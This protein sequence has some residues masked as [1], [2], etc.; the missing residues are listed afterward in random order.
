MKKYGVVIL[1]AGDATRLQLDI[2]KGLVKIHGAS[3]LERILKKCPEDVAIMTSIKNHE[4]IKEHVEALGMQ[5]K[6]FLFFS[7]K[8]A[9]VLGSDTWSP[10]GN[11]DLF[12]AFADSGVFQTF[13]ERGVERIVVCPV[14]NP[15]VQ[16][17]FW[18]L[19]QNVELVVLAVEKKSENE[20]VGTIFTDDKLSVKEYTS[21]KNSEGLAY[22]GIFSAALSFFERAARMDPLVKVH[23]I[24]KVQR[25]VEVVKQEKFVFDFFPLARTFEVVKVD[26]NAHFLPIKRDVGTDSLEDALRVLS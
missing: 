18:G 24:K 7:Q 25:G 2:P 1:A 19:H 21:F 10:M 4:Q 6:R 3:L 20:S 5:N 22:A 26:R 16:P 12:R 15:L 11:G 9:P 17:G 8:S 14:D 13:Q 23:K